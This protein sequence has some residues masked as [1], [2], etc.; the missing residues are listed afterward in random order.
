MRTSIFVLG[1]ADLTAAMVR[2]KAEAPPS[3]RSS[4]VTE[5]M[6]AYP[7]PRALTAPATR[8]GSSGS[9]GEGVPFFTAQKPQ[10]RVQVSPRMRN[11][12]V[13]RDQ[14]SPTLGHRALWQIVWRRPSFTIPETRK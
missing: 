12:A 2:A 14:H 6:T 5:V 1:D 11:V 8:P 4:R 13:F 9:R 3:A 10:A 7:R